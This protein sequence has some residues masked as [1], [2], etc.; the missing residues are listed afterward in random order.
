MKVNLKFGDMPYLASGTVSAKRFV[1][2]DGDVPSAGAIALGVNETDV[3]SGEYGVAIVNG[4]P[5]VEA[6]GA[7]SVDGPVTPGTGGKAVAAGTGD[8]VMGWAVDEASGNGEFIRI[9]LSH[10]R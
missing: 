2:A 7:I 1:A 9:I 5:V 10:G 3:V 6:G 4:V 8:K